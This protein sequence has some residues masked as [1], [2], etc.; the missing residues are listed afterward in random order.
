M[1]STSNSGS[2]TNSAFWPL[3]LLLPA[4]P[5]ALVYANKYG[6]KKQEVAPT[7]SGPV[8][9]SAKNKKKNNK[10]KSKTATPV[11]R[12]VAPSPAPAAPVV[13]APEPTP[14]PT[15][16]PASVVAPAT[17]S[18]EPAEPTEAPLTKSA[19]KNKRRK[20]KA[21]T[22]AAEQ[23]TASAK[24]PAAPKGSALV[25]EP[26]AAEAQ[27]DNDDGWQ[28]TR[29]ERKSRQRSQK[30]AAAAAAAAA[31][32][33]PATAAVGENATP[34]AVAPS[35]TGASLSAESTSPP[36]PAAWPEQEP[37]DWGNAP[38]D[39]G[40]NNDVIATPGVPDLVVPAV[41]EPVQAS[42]ESASSVVDEPVVS[43]EQPTSR[44]SRKA[45]KQSAAELHPSEFF[46]APRVVTPV[47]HAEPEWESVPSRGKRDYQVQATTG[48]GEKKAKKAA[49]LAAQAP[50]RSFSSA[51]AFSMLG[52]E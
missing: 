39:E 30:A 4:I 12:S 29:A 16:A 8:P 38:A 5:I 48:Q 26:V 1:P 25:L 41:H 31:P 23:P 36:T 44:R 47:A 32:A 45:A 27:T 10:S 51:N 21:A 50:G 52:N 9:G 18:P 35:S 37:I 22:A 24:Q 14:A 19:K 2:N 13:K 49:A 42:S 20:N 11:Q 15:P 40:W 43:A 33:V 6:A 7:A 28:T 17:P 3:V 46:S 34:L